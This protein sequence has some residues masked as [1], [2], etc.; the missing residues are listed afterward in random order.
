MQTSITRT[1]L[2]VLSGLYLFLVYGYGILSSTAWS[3]DYAYLLDPDAA[4][5]HAVKDGRLVYGGFIQLLFGEFDSISALRFIRI[6]GFLGLLLLSDLILRKLL[7][8]ENSIRVAAA[9]TIAFTLPSFQF[10]AHW[11]TAFMMCWSA[12]LAVQGYLLQESKFGVVKILGFISMVSSLLFYPLYSF[13]LFAFIFAFWIVRK[14]SYKLLT[15]EFSKGFYL[16]VVCSVIGY[17]LSYGYLMAFGLNFNPRV[18]FV[19]L[20]SIVSKLVFFFSRP[21]ALTYLPFVIDSPSFIRFVGTVSAFLILL[22]VLIWFR[23]RDIQS[24]VLVF[25]LFNTFSIF[26]LLPLIAVADNQIDMRFVASNTW[27]FVFVIV[28]LSVPKNLFSAPKFHYKHS[29]GLLIISSSLVFGALSVNHNFRTFY[30]APYLEKVAFLDSQVSA[31]SDEQIRNQVTI[32]KRTIPWEKKNAI[33]A[34][35]QQTDLE[36]DWVPI[37]AVVYYLKNKGYESISL[38]ELTIKKN[39]SGNCNIFLDDYP[40]L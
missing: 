23:F 13:F 26:T 14:E 24:T 15:K 19:D 28:F 33:G 16:I 7:K 20:T 11:A 2:R 1:H 6:I 30:K 12:Y 22:I 5:L 9:T 34:Y 8:S 3:D 4:A 10:S 40:R 17:V 27:L 18:G 31:C 25:V 21:F 35:S 39:L 36:S 32:V 37:G 38:P 29:L